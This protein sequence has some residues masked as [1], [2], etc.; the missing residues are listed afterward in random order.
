MEAL[1]PPPPQQ[2]SQPQQQPQPQQQQQRWFPLESNPELMNQYIET[3]GFD[4]H[5]YHFCD[6]YS[7]EDWALEMIPQPVAAVI[8]LYP[9]TPV[10]L[11]YDQQQEQQ[12]EQAKKT[13][14]DESSS[15]AAVPH[16][17][18]RT[19]NDG[20]NTNNNGGVWFMKQRIG[21]ACGT[22]GIL[23][24]LLNVDRHVWDESVRP[25]SWLADFRDRT[26]TT[27]T[28]TTSLSSLD[29]RNMMDATAKAEV[30]ENDPIISTLHEAAT[31]DVANATDRGTID[32][33]VITHFIALVR[34]SSNNDTTAGGQL[35]ECDGRKPHAICH[36]TCPTAAD[37]LPRAVDVIQQFMARDPD[38]V[39]FTIL[40]LA[41]NH[42]NNTNDDDDPTTT[43]TM[44]G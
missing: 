41:P 38:E 9:L 40:A 29:G 1:P 36:G 8:F 7:T 37:L 10:Q 18:D 3:M 22:V 43:T 25:G 5:R 33:D 32:D 28:I 24:S 17:P 44:D 4:T 34:T 42:Q 26:T 19:N 11:A 35:Y 12:Q 14:D 27:T 30:L 31:N 39:R 15:P 6:V 21:N 20:D 23:H 16:V 13:K 2:Q